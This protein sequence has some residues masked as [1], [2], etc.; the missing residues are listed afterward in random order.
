[1]AANELIKMYRQLH[2][3]GNF[4]GYS[5]F[6]CVATITNLIERTEAKTLLDYGSGKGNQYFIKK[7]HHEWG[8]I[9][10]TLYDPGIKRYKQ[11][12][13]REFDGV[14]CTDV[15]EHLPEEEV[16]PTIQNLFEYANLFIVMS[17]CTRKADKTLPDGRNC[18]LTIKPYEWWDK[19]IKHIHKAQPTL[20]VNTIYYD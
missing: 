15:L 6:P 20:E 16:E 8:G 4:H 11:L 18:H 3:Q 12:P 9:L 19:I 13:S 7:V 1:M 14:I 5:I 2:R 17:I 10:P